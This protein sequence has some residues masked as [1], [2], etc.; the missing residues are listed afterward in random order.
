MAARSV[1]APGA[2]LNAFDAWRR[3]GVFSARRFRRTCYHGVRHAGRTWRG[4]L[5]MLYVAC[6]RRGEWDGMAW[7]LKYQYNM[8]ANRRNVSIS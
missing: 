7:Q 6:W 1:T 5:N 4:H 2:A 3:A 8:R